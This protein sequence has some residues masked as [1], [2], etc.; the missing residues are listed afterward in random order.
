VELP[1][2]EVR[3]CSGRARQNGEAFETKVGDGE[4]HRAARSAAGRMHPAGGG[5]RRITSAYA[6]TLRAPLEH[7]AGGLQRDV[8]KMRYASGRWR[9]R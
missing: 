5:K 6:V 3:N 2:E 9:S 1:G 4:D 7:N 8:L